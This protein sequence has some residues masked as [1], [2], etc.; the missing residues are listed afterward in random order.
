MSGAATASGCTWR[1]GSC[2]SSRS[3]S[4][5]GCRASSGGSVS[6]HPA[7]FPRSS[8]PL[9]LTESLLPTVQDYWAA[10]NGIFDFTFAPKPGVD[11]A[12]VRRYVAEDVILQRGLNISFASNG[13]ARFEVLLSHFGAPLGSYLTAAEDTGATLHWNM[14]DIGSNEAVASGHAEL[15]LA[16]IRQGTVASLLNATA[17][18]PDLGTMASVLRPPMP[19]SLSCE[20]VV[21]G[22][23]VAFNSWRTNLYP[24]YEDQAS[25]IPIV[26]L[27]ASF[28]SLLP[29]SNLRVFDPNEQ[30]PAKKVW[31][32]SSGSLD[33]RVLSDV[34]D[35]GVLLLLGPLSSQCTGSSLGEVF[36]TTR[37]TTWKS[38]WWQGSPT[39]TNA[40]TLLYNTS[41]AEYVFKGMAPDGFADAA[42]FSLVDKASPFRLRANRSL[43]YLVFP[44]ATQAIPIPAVQLVDPS[45]AKQVMIS[46]KFEVHMRALDVVTQMSDDKA[47][48]FTATFG[49][50]IVVASSLNVFQAMGHTVGSVDSAEKSWVLFRLC[51]YAMQLASKGPGPA[52]GVKTDDNVRS[53]YEIYSPNI[54]HS[55]VVDKA[56]SRLQ[57]N[58]GATVARFRDTLI[59]LW[60]GNTYAKEGHGSQFIEASQSTDNG[61][62]WSSP[63][64]AFSAPEHAS[65]PIACNK[66]CVQWQPNLVPIDGGKRLGCAWS[67][68]WIVLKPG[69]DPELARCTKADRVFWSVLDSPSARWTTRTLTFD[70]SHQV[71]MNGTSF[72]VFPTEQPARLSSGRLLVPVTLIS[73]GRGLGQHFAEKRASVVIS[74]DEMQ[75]Y[76]V[77]AGTII[78]GRPSSQWETTVWQPTGATNVVYMFDRA[79]D[80]IGTP[81]NSYPLPNA[82]LMHATSSD[83]GL[84][85][86][87]LTAVNVETIVARSLVTPLKKPLFLLTMNDWVQ[88]SSVQDGS[89]RKNVAL[90]FNRGGG[91]NFVQGP[92]FATGESYS[93]YPQATFDEATNRATIVYTSASSIKAAVVDPMPDPARS[94]VFPRT[95]LPTL[96]SSAP[97]LGEGALTFATDSR[98]SFLHS[99]SAIGSLGDNFS[100]AVWAKPKC[101]R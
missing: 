87:P 15:N 30:L 76:T 96:F 99:R 11:P 88:R 35:G 2:G 92:G 67:L 78:A 60:N 98:S 77:S 82:S 56:V 72:D 22:S 63:V 4:S 58:H 18:L 43:S 74:D 21:G 95:N 19:L 66:S 69:D 8:R 68:C 44:N 61:A 38:A 45:P 39:N 36:E 93:V 81:N 50:G 73:N 75:S 5:P 85:W 83:S 24:A 42:W 80:G 23:S 79:N 1:R 16:S 62:H 70:G 10:S 59:A 34:L 29:Y 52:A 101:K 32:G 6:P 90:W 100:L 89:D 7:L 46:D 3:A 91:V 37:P 57:Y 51:E 9:V 31:A 14:T 94:Y 17:K 55:F 47:F 40:G 48:F 41:A 54:S 71:M 25:S 33:P 12:S 49:K 86:T 97:T 28:N 20:V 53:G 27:N 84:T 65:N 64:R 13:T 26:N